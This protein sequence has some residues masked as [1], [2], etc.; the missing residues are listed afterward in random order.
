MSAAELADAP[1]EQAAFELF[2]A[3]DSL[4][5]RPVDQSAVSLAGRPISGATSWVEGDL[6]VGQRVFGADRPTRS[7]VRRPSDP[8]GRTAF[9]RSAVLTG[10]AEP[11]SVVDAVRMALRHDPALWRRRLDAHASLTLPVGL[12]D[13]GG[14]LMRRV[15]V[16]LGP[17]RGVALV[18]ATS[19]ARPLP[20]PCSSRP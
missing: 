20:A 15:S 17:D 16:M 9:A 12:V 3:A 6:A 14:P 7:P 2:V 1:V 5:V 11:R 8:D 4:E 18:G 10:I 19:S 13:D